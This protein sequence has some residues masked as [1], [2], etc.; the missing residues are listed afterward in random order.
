MAKD[1][2]RLPPGRHR[3]GK[4]HDPCGVACWPVGM[5][6]PFSTVQQWPPAGRNLQ[7][8]P[9]PAPLLHW[10]RR[11]RVHNVVMR[12]AHG[13]GRAGQSQR[14][15]LARQVQLSRGRWTRDE[16]AGAIRSAGWRESVT[17][18]WSPAAP[19]QHPPRS[20]AARWRPHSTRPAP[21]IAEVLAAST[22]RLLEHQPRGRMETAAS[23]RRQL[24]TA[25]R[26]LPPVR[27]DSLT[28]RL[29]TL[30]D[31][32]RFRENAHRAAV[33]RCYVMGAGRD[34][35]E[36]DLGILR[37]EGVSG[38]ACRGLLR[39]RLPRGGKRG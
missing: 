9:M 38:R 3:Q 13:H 1:P 4:G 21:L 26:A 17:V 5:G 31:G 11:R 7:R 6:G 34:Q 25:A 2:G 32:G 10:R 16:Q 22:R 27:P 8:G 36:S 24:P 15:W 35:G 23:R 37:A 33:L 30:R 19:P 39:R 14:L 18:T 20:C 28:W 12:D 29:A